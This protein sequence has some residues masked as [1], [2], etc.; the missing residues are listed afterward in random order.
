MKD[1]I[2][3]QQLKTKIQELKNAIWPMADAAVVEG[4]PVYHALNEDVS[5]YLNQWQPLIDEALELYAPL[6]DDGEER[7]VPS[8]LEIPLIFKNVERIIIN[9]SKAKESKTFRSVAALIEKCGKFEDDEMVALQTWLESDDTAAFVAH[10]EFI[11]LRAYIFIK[12]REEYIRSR[13][14]THGLLV[15]VEPGFTVVDNRGKVRK[16]RND[17]FK[18]HIAQNEN[19]KVFGKYR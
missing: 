1:E 11:D 12:G 19:W 3:I 17:T 2:R 16:E 18:D 13:F 9:K 14:Y 15:G 5:A 10:R 8:H 6:V 7:V 4:L